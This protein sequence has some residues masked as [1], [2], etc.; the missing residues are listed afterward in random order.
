MSGVSAFKKR[1][2]SKDPS[3]MALG[4]CSDEYGV[5]HNHLK[6]PVDRSVSF[7]GVKDPEDISWLSDFYLL[8][9]YKDYLLL[10]GVE[11]CSFDQYQIMSYFNVSSR[12]KIISGTQ[13]LRRI[14]LEG[15]KSAVLWAQV[16]DD[17]SRGL[18]SKKL[19]IGITRKSLV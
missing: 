15:G 14:P 10:L 13:R 11:T 7:E 8:K 19:Y 12:S 2:V 18:V 9:V 5:A 6:P 3:R 4:N 17:Y 16:C 1:K